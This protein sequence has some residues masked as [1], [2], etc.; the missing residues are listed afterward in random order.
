MLLFYLRFLKIYS[1]FFVE[2]AIKHALKVKKRI[3]KQ[4]K[5]CADAPFIVIE[6]SDEP[7]TSAKSLKPKKSTAAIEELDSS[8]EINSI[9][10]Q[11]K[12]PA[13]DKEAPIEGK[14]PKKTLKILESIET[15]ENKN[16][17]IKKD[18]QR[19]D[20]KA[21]IMSAKPKQLNIYS[22]PTTTT[23][24]TMP[25]SDKKNKRKIEEPKSIWTSS[26]EFTITKMIPSNIPKS[27]KITTNSTDFFV[28]PLDTKSIKKKSTASAV[29]TT[30][31]V[32]ANLNAVN[33]KQ[34][35][36]FGKHIN[37]ETSQ[38][39]L[40]RKHKQKANYIL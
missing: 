16:F 29:A 31:A 13:T 7:S 40:Q 38:Q 17:K 34:Q 22:K 5:Q 19:D 35:A 36:L 39:L 9:N 24:E 11:R 32:A 25:K 12:R 27:R 8:T 33:F 4:G 6:N 18:K 30:S 10:K 15:N 37:R 3:L 1:I 20:K 26:G 23:D 21:D 2:A 14:R 28:T